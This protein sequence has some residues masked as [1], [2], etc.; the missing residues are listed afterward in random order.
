[1]LALGE[2]LSTCVSVTRGVKVAL[3]GVPLVVE[4][5]VGLTERVG[6]GEPEVVAVCVPVPV[7]RPVVLRS[8]V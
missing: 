2:P 4:E 3:P 6:E 8:G 5:E 1:L 7:A